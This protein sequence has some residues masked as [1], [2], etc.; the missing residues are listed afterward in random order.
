MLFTFLLNDVISCIPLRERGNR[1]MHIW[2][3]MT[4]IILIMFSLCSC[5][6]KNNEKSQEESMRRF[7]DVTN[8]FHKFRTNSSGDSYYF[9]L[10]EFV[11]ETKIVKNY[12]GDDNQFEEYGLFGPVKILKFYN[13]VDIDFSYVEIGFSTLNH[14]YDKEYAKSFAS[15]FA[16]YK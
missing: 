14:E 9:V 13:D 5:G 2:E 12:Y 6:S 16:N 15:T 10:F 3:T 4:S 1:F 11:G 7:P 8:L